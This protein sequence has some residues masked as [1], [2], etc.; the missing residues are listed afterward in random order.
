MVIMADWVL[1]RE[2]LCVKPFKKTAKPSQPI[3]L[4]TGT[5]SRVGKVREMTCINPEKG[6]MRLVVQFAEGHNPE[7]VYIDMPRE[8]ARLYM[9]GQTIRVDEAWGPA[10]DSPS[11]K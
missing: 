1:A 8:E 4:H 10:M 6:I 11:G 2:I 9:P 7:D 5:R 3:N